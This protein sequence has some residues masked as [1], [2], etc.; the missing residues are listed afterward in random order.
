MPTRAREV[1][2]KKKDGTE[3]IVR[4]KKVAVRGN[5]SK[6]LY[7]EGFIEDITRR[8]QTEEALKA[9]EEN[10]RNSIANS[11]T[12]IR[13][14]DVREQTFYVNQA[15]LDIFGYENIE[16]VKTSPPTEYYT[17]ESYTDSVSRKK[18]LLRGE[19]IPG[20]IEVDIIR[21]DGN[22]RHL[23]ISRKD[24]FWNGKQES[25]I[26]YNDITEGKR[27]EVAPGNRRFLFN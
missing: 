5:D 15:F 16:E 26:V 14:G 22:I 6:T 2:F 27:T 1:C 23:Q 13:I 4:D 20:E 7:L 18:K 9:S 8:K 17:P 12:G 11:S 19:T 3:I 21:K 25:Q 24:I 10:F